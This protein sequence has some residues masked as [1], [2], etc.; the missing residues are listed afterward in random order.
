MKKLKRSKFNGLIRIRKSQIEWLKLNRD[1]RTI[2]GFL[3]KIINKHKKMIKPKIREKI[4]K[5]LE[6]KEN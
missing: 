5:G 4:N 2:A 3:D 1:C 6:S